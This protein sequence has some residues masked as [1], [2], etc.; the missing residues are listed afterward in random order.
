MTA[1]EYLNDLNQRYIAIHRNK[2]DL[3]WDTYMG[4][5]DD[6]DGAAHSQA[7]WT[8]FLSNAEQI[9]AIKK[10]LELADSIEGSL[11]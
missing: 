3:F 5:S 6:H 7:K 9:T 11:Y 10:Q 2:E 1:T 8:N 4:T